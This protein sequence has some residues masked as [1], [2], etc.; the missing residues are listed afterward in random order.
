MSHSVKLRFPPIPA[1]SG[2]FDLSMTRR[3]GDELAGWLSD[4]EG[5]VIVGSTYDVLALIAATGLS[6]FTPGPRLES[7]RNDDET[8]ARL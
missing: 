4:Y 3:E 7:G 8:P 2:R 6:A 5:L 1:I